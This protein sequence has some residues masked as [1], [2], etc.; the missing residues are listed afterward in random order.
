MQKKVSAASVLAVVALSLLP[1]MPAKAQSPYF[2]AVTNL[3]P[4]AYWPLQESVQPPTAN[5][6]TNLGSFG[7]VANAYYASTNVIQ[8]FSPGATGDGDTAVEFL[9][10]NSGFMIVPTTDNRVSLPAGQPFTVETWAFATGGNQFVSMVNQTGPIGA[11]GNN[12]GPNSA[13]WSLNQNWLPYKGTATGNNSL[14]GWSFHVFNGSGSTGGAEADAA[15]AFNLNQWYHIVGVFDGV[16]CTVYVD[17]VNATTYQIPMSGSYVPDTWD[18]IQFGGNRGLGANPYHGAVDDV[19]IYTNALTAAQIANHYAAV[20]SG[21]A[22]TIL[23]DNPVMYWR[24]DAPAYTQPPVSSYPTA[25]NYGSASITNFNTAGNTAVYQP[26]SVPGVAGPSYSGFGNQTNACAFNGIVGAVDGGYNALLDPTGNVS[27]NSPYTLVAW[28]QGNPTDNNGR[29]NTLASHSDKS[30]R[31]K[32]NNGQS[33]WNGG[34]SAQPGIAASLANVNDGN[35]HMLAGVSDGTNQT[36]WVDGAVFS[37]VTNQNQTIT[38]ANNKDVFL[39]GAPDFLEPTNGQYNTGQQYLAGKLAHVSY[40]TNALSQAQIQNLYSVAVP[41]AAPVIYAQPVTGRTNNAG[42]AFL[43]FGVFAGGTYPLTYQWY[44][45]A[46]PTYS[47]ATALIDDGIKYSGSTSY[48]VTVSNLVA[49]DS[50]YY[51][52]VVGNSY[53]SVTSILSSLSVLTT[54]V[55][56]SQTPSGAF[57]LYPNQIE[58]LSITATGPGPLS[59]QWY[60]NGVADTISGTAASYSVTGQV[61]MSGFTYQCVVGN[62]FGTTTGALDT[63]TVTPYPA[64]IANSAYA[65]NILALSPSGYWPMHEIAASPSVSIET[66]YGSLGAL[67]NGYWADWVAPIVTHNVPGAITNDSDTAVQFYNTGGDCLIIPHFTP[68]A[69]IKAPYTLEAWI[70]PFANNTLSDGSYQVI[71]GQGGATGLNGSANHGGFA[72]QYSGTPNTFSLVIWNGN[73][74]GSYEQKTTAIYPPGVWY[75]VVS[76]FDGTNVAYYINGQQA[77]FGTVAG[78]PGPMNPDSW[79]PLCIGAGR[80]GGSGAAQP[81]IGAM[82]E[83]AIYTN[84]LAPSD[85][86]T[87]YNDGVGGAAGAY[88]ADVLADNPLFYF[89]MDSPAYTAPP[90]NTWPV[91]TNYGSSTVNGVYHPGAVPGGA[92]GPSESGIRVANLSGTNAMQGNGVSSF[93][94]AGISPTLN[95]VNYTSF[96]YSAWFKGIPADDRSFQGIM[97]AN[98]N[99]WRASINSSGLVQA[100]G[101]ADITSTLPYNDGNWHQFV[102]TAQANATAGNYTN[103]LY[104]DGVLVKSG[105][106]N[107][108]NNP[109]ATSQPSPEVL[110]GSETGFTNSSSSG[111]RS[112]AGNICEAAFFYGTVLSSNQVRA[113]Y[114]SAG[115]AP[116]FEIQPVSASVNQGSLFTNTPVV[117]GSDTL[118]FQWYENNVPIGNQTNSILVLNPVQASN[119]STNYYLVVTNGYGSATSSVVSLTVFTSPTIGSQLPVTYTNLFTLYAAAS[120]LFSV[121]V[122]GASPLHY[123]WYTNGVIVPGAT[124]PAV[125]LFNVQAGPLTNYCIITNFLGSITSQVWTASVVA[126]PAAYPEMLLSM[127][128]ITY[129]RLNEPDDSLGDGNPGAIAHDYA[130]GEDGIYTNVA[131]GQTGY[132]AFDP[133]TAPLFGLLYG[134]SNSVTFGIQG[135]DFSAPTNTSVGFTVMAW[136]KGAEN[137]SVTAAG[138]VAKGLFNNEE[139]TL[140]VGNGLPN[141]GGKAYRFEVRSANGTAYNANSTLVANDNAWHHLVGVCDEANSNVT[142][143]VDGQ[144]AGSVAIPAGA[145]IMGSNSNVPVTIGSRSS[146]AANGNDNQFYGWINDVAIF[147]YPMSVSQVRSIYDGAGVPPYFTEEPPANVTTSEGLTLT[148]PAADDGTAPITNQWW[149]ATANAPIAG[150]TNTTLVISNVSSDL[151][152][153]QIYLQAANAYGL[154]NSSM[155]TLAILHGPPEITLNVTP[156]Y[157]V[158]YAG[159]LVTYSITA[160]GSQPLY[161]QWYQ[162]GVAVAGATNS[163]YSV[164]APLGTNTFSCSVSNTYNGGSITSSSTATLVGTDTHTS[165]YKVVVLSDN[166]IAYWRLDEGPDNGAGNDG[167]IAHDIVGGH[168]AI[169]NNTVLGLTGY[170]TNDSDTAAGFGIFSNTNSYAQEIDLSGSGTPNIDFSQSPGGNAEFSVETWVNAATNQTLNNRILNKGH[171]FGEQFALDLGTVTPST[172]F[173]F[174]IRDANANEYDARSTIV[175]D[176]KWHHLVGVCDESNGVIALYVDGVLAATNFNNVVLT[177]GSGLYSVSELMSMG[178]A[179]TDRNGGGIWGAQLIG[180]IDEPALYNYPL[181]AAQVAGHYQAGIAQPPLPLTIKNLGGGLLQLNWGSAILQSATNVTGPYNDVSGATPPYTVPTT[182]KQQFYRTRE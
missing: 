96:S 168:N 9:G 169:Y 101:N 44:H 59:Y 156:P 14:L 77:S 56:T 35:W 177:P 94:D 28:F 74:G 46:N 99:T 141:N 106:N 174:T 164:P 124:N 92:A 32:I 118:V 149:D 179:D 79:S 3:N 21:Y 53:G 165:P 104:V 29:W 70:K 33:L 125:T 54:P 130:G 170:N 103:S 72:L 167:V 126:P 153:H 138:V 11:G 42:T 50:G 90:A 76:T 91:L 81:F 127:D 73:G 155:V 143:Y 132:S 113:L 123:Q 48:Q 146:G 100:H 22:G 109:F 37:S 171:F 85:I 139:F 16:N 52:V 61:G 144:L 137:Q 151:D 102:V 178:N 117:G 112:L 175:P 89:R 62:S 27:T 84:L 133:E 39:G 163:S 19:A 82:D 78:S 114:S 38:G 43:F 131:L 135:I 88:K 34:T 111:G 115:V 93:A 116:F 60:T 12:A 2:Q 1:V 87:H 57:S 119:N 157:K 152:G 36:V 10:N 67:G 145:G 18:P 121:T 15:Y 64:S 75:H 176:G 128:P 23:S 40:F 150:Q 166:P 136:A 181:T 17:G 24:M 4:I 51:F 140:D 69:T 5:V 47:G 98:D 26:G 45:N 160:N 122:S 41:H 180:V 71:M 49:S 148:V 55:I 20:G 105:A 129:W 31:L 120:P 147:K 6:E 86:Q 13:G 30:W 159:T 97:S 110:I 108:T 161:Y 63:L 173:R 80:W 172:A 154:T 134:A 65:T 182:N 25:A 58:N 83:V 107:G 7:S 66:N 68:L 142:F 162:D 8:Q 158:V 95:P